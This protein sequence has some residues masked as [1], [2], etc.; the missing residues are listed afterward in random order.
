[1]A[2]ILCNASCLKC[3]DV[4]LKSEPMS[5]MV[6]TLCDGFPIEDAKHF[7]IQCPHLENK[8]SEMLRQLSEI[9]F[10]KQYESLQEPLY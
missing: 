10:G 6:C 5:S 1:M 9:D 8:R 3:D 7:V 4:C 2:E